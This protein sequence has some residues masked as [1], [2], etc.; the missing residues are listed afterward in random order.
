MV[1]WF[2]VLIKLVCVWLFGCGEG[3]KIIKNGYTVGEGGIYKEGKKINVYGLNWFG[4]ETCVKAPHGLEYRTVDDYMKIIKQYGF[5]ALR[6]PVSLDVINNNGVVDRQKVSADPD[7]PS[8]P[9]Q[10]FIYV[11]NKAKE[12]GLYVVI[13]FHNFNCNNIDKNLEG[14]IVDKKAWFDALSKLAEIS[15]NY[16]N[17]IGID[18]FNEPYKL[19]WNEWK[20]LFMQAFDVI[21]KINNNLLVIV[22][23]IG[24]DD[25]DVKDY[26]V[27]WGEN[28]SKAE[29]ISNKILYTPHVY[30]PSYALQ[31]Y[32]KS[33]DLLPEVW[34][35]HFGHLYYFA[36]G[37]FGSKFTD[38]DK[39]WE[40]IFIDYMKKKG[41]N[42]WFYWALNGDTDGGFFT[43]DWQNINQNVVNFLNKLKF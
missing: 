42:V 23:G 14:Y 32:F 3:Y 36:L 12:N 25:E 24:N 8:E 41:V 29:Y 6:L 39:Q 37:E 16:D 28:L 2:I 40:E 17:V 1:R 13:D 43:P 33:I 7:Y 38:I 26:P 15:K 21:M 27:F 5:N 9:L 35:M 20:N 34:D 4:F 10:G 18:I 11:L 31:P 19:S 30:S 22:Q